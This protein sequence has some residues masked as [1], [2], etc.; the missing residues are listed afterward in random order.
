MDVLALLETVLFLL[1]FYVTA[2]G[3]VEFS[4]RGEL[5]VLSSF[6]HSR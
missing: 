2:L 3:L 4:G 5:S 1:G 6:S